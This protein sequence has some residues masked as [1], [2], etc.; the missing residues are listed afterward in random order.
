M[1]LA[2]I[3]DL[4]AVQIVG[5]HLVATTNDRH[6]IG[7]ETRHSPMGNRWTIS[8]AEAVP[9]DP[10]RNLS[11]YGNISGFLV[12]DTVEDLMGEGTQRF[13]R[14]LQSYDV[15]SGLVD[16]AVKIYNC[17]VQIA[18]EEADASA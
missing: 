9:P 13:R 5:Q 6:R 8:L 12:E 3:T 4:G 11:S 18:E 2:S 1:T 16:A 14:W 15:D 10:T 17:L 7:F